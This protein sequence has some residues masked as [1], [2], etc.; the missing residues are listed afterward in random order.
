MKSSVLR[1]MKVL[2]AGMMMVPPVPQDLK[3]ASMA[4]TSSVLALSA[5]VGVHVARLVTP[6]ILREKSELD[7]T[8]AASTTLG[9]RLTRRIA[10]CIVFVKIWTRN[11]HRGVVIIYFP[12]E[13]H[14]K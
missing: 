11:D 6:S 13:L 1:I 12:G 8:E 5:E 9:R 7:G 3:A 14:P 4:G 2:P 10:L